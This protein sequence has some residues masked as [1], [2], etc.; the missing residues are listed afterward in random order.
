MKRAAPAPVGGG[1]RSPAA[2]ALPPLGV[3]CLPPRRPLLQVHRP[4][5][6]SAVRNGS[7]S[8][9]ASFRNGSLKR[10]FQVHRPQHASAASAFLSAALAAANVS[11]AAAAE[12]ERDQ[13]LQKVRV[14]R[15]PSRSKRAV[16]R[17][18]R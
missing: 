6:A 3:T 15:Q 2:D 11:P 7:L 1:G 12:L 14:R 16:S 13:E 8:L 5:H 4:Q 10:L 9:T 17:K 18:C